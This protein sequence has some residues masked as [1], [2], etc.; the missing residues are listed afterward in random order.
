MPVLVRALEQGKEGFTER[1]R[2]LVVRG[3]EGGKG[4]RGGGGEKKGGERR[5]GE[6]GLG[7]M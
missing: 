3:K 6:R 2:G 5:G 4:G 1:E 7:G